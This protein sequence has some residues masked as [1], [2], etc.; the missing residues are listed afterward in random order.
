MNR[1]GTNMLLPFFSVAAFLL[2]LTILLTVSSMSNPAST[3]IGEVPEK[4]LETYADAESIRIYASLA[5]KHAVQNT[6]VGERFEERILQNFMQQMRSHELHPVHD[7]FEVSELQG[8]YRFR[9]TEDVE[10]SIGGGLE[11]RYSGAFTGWP[12]DWPEEIVT[13]L[14]GRRDDASPY[15]AGIDLRALDKGTTVYSLA[16]GTVSSVGSYFL[17]VRH[18]NGWTCGYLHVIPEKQLGER[19]GAGERIAGIEDIAEK[20]L[21]LRC[22]WHENPLTEEQAIALFGKERVYSPNKPAPKESPYVHF[23]S[24]GNAF[25]DPYC[26]LGPDRF[27]DASFRSG[28]TG[29]RYREGF[30]AGAPKTQM[31]EE[32]CRAYE[33]AGL[34]GFGGAVTTPQ[35]VQDALITNTIREHECGLCYRS[36]CPGEPAGSPACYT[37]NPDDPGGATRWGVTLGTLQGWRQTQTGDSSLALTA[38]DVKQLSEAEAVEIYKYDFFEQ[39]RFDRLPAEI[40]PQIFDI[41][42]L[43]GNA[44]KDILIDTLNNHYGY[45]LE[46]GNTVVTEE[47]ASE[48]RKIIQSVPADEGGGPEGLNNAIV[49][50]RLKVLRANPNVDKFPGWIDRAESFRDTEGYVGAVQAAVR[51]SAIGTYVF[52]LEVE[53]QMPA[54]R[55]QAQQSYEQLRQTLPR[56]A[57]DDNACIESLLDATRNRLPGLEACTATTDA[58]FEGIKTCQQALANG[59]CSCRVDL[60]PQDMQELRFATESMQVRTD[61]GTTE[62][63]YDLFP[64][65]PDLTLEITFLAEEGDEVTVSKDVTWSAGATNLQGSTNS[66]S[67]ESLEVSQGHFWMTPTSIKGTPFIKLTQQPIEP[68]CA[69]SAPRKYC[70]QEGD[71]W[72]EHPKQ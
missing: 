39:P 25:I 36:S 57:A 51:T 54:A 2:L 10:L 6:S 1:K 28:I 71:F 3:K 64:N 62:V 13:S 65:T 35:A 59:D 4:V 38:D 44:W 29:F 68:A 47:L 67:V 8:S 63:T 11:A 15:T 40:L 12:V 42:V 18:E 66:G 60:P 56:C 24:S 26:L 17:Y 53:A 16:P 5:A 43:Q 50:E 21:D 46:R 61:E 45:Q 22:Y 23:D 37:N 52:P 30:D 27:T 19:V 31:A 58:L 70:S 69:V 32:T 33:A 14:F 7:P 20:H 49:D 55:I 9:A 72:I 41:S 34:P 48:L